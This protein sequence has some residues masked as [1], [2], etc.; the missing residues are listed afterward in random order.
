[1]RRAF[2]VFKVFAFLL[3]A[4]PLAACSSNDDISETIDV[5][6][7]APREEIAEIGDMPPVQNDAPTQ[8]RAPV[9]MADSAALSGNRAVEVYGFDAPVNS[10]AAGS[11]FL[12]SNNAVQS[13]PRVAR[14][15]A[16]NEN[17]EVFPLDGPVSQPA[18]NQPSFV[19]PAYGGLQSQQMQQPA[20]VAQQPAP[21]AAPA[22]VPREDAVNYVSMKIQGL[23]GEIIYFDH[24]D[25]SVNDA[26]LATVRQIAERFKGGGVDVLSVEGHA[27]ARAAID[28]PVQ[29]R[30]VN[31]RVSMQRAFNVAK[32]LVEAGVPAKAV[33][34][35]AWGD[36]YAQQGDSAE[37]AARRVEILP[38][39]GQK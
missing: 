2:G 22:I 29:R 8:N 11:N 12:T 9:T 36:S 14:G 34:A 25:I 26:G 13:A 33:R 17:V 38:M 15:F 35:V 23:G 5:T 31:L 39:T 3:V 18:M 16:V 19:P 10:N 27:S 30:V 4:V 6:N 21:A 32:A 24:S 28:D 1:M 20:Q 37:K 7:T